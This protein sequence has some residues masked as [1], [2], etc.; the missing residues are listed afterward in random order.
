LLV[1]HWSIAVSIFAIGVAAKLYARKT[2]DRF[3]KQLRLIIESELVYR[4]IFRKFPDAI[5]LV[6]R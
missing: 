3:Q 4:K 2:A 1:V 6:E 5:I